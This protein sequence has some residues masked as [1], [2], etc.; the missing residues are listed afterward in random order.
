MDEKHASQLPWRALIWG[1]LIAGTLDICAAFILAWMHDHGP[2]FILQGI[3]SAILGPASFEGGLATAALGLAM[4]FTIAFSI[5]AAYC[6]LSLRFPLLVR[7]PVASG[8]LWGALVYLMM[9]RGILP[10][11]NLLTSLYLGNYDSTLPHM[12]LRMLGIH[13]VCV[14]LP[15]ALARAF[16]AKA[17][18]KTL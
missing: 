10:L 15:I 13:V 2:M 5:T 12:G 8:I 3:A 11:V 17:E 4:H 14:G 9:Y 1:G 7:R 18:G 16:F 6:L